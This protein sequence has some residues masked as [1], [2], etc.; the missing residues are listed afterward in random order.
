MRRKRQLLYTLGCLYACLA[1]LPL[2]AQLDAFQLYMDVDEAIFEQQICLDIK[3]EGAAQLEGLQFSLN[4]NPIELQYRG[5]FNIY[6]PLQ[7]A[8]WSIGDNDA[9]EGIVR[10]LMYDAAMQHDIPD[11]TV[12]AQ[13]CF[14]VRGKPGSSTPIYISDYTLEKRV[15]LNGQDGD[16]PLYRGDLK[17]VSDTTLNLYKSICASEV[18]DSSGIISVTPIGGRPPYQFSF[19]HFQNTN[20]NGLFGIGQEGKTSNISNLIPGRYYLRLRDQ[21]NTLF[22]DTVNVNNYSALRYNKI[23]T[24]PDC[25]SHNN[26]SI[27]INQIRGW[28]IPLFYS[29]GDGTLFFNQRDSLLAGEYQFRIQDV[30]NC[31]E[32]V[33][34]N[35]EAEGLQIEEIVQAPTCFGDA[36]GQLDIL[37]S[38]GTLSADSS[39][40]L[41]F[42]GDTMDIHNYTWENQAASNIAF[43]IFD[44]AA[45]CVIEREVQIPEGLEL[46]LDTILVNPI[47]CYGKQSGNALVQVSRIHGVDDLLLRYELIG[48]DTQLTASDNLIFNDLAAGTYPLIISDSNGNCAINSYFEMEQPTAI[49]LV[50]TSFLPVHC[51]D[52]NDGAIW[53]KAAGGTPDT[54]G[55]TY[56]WSNGIKNDSVQG[57]PS[58]WIE[59]TVK[60]AA[61]CTWD[62]SFYVHYE[63]GKQ[64]ENIV[65]TGFSCNQVAT[66][67]LNASL[68]DD[69]LDVVQ[70]IWS[71][72]KMGLSIDSLLPGNY[73][74]YIQDELQCWDTLSIDARPENAPKINQLIV[75][76]IRC[77]NEQNGS[78]EPVLE[79]NAAAYSYLWSNGDTTDRVTGLSSGAYWVIVR[80][81][82]NCADTAA[83]TL[84]NPDSLYYTID[85][86]HD[87]AQ[88]ALGEIIVRVRGGAKPYTI[89]WN[90]ATSPTDSILTDLMA[91]D[92]YLEIVD[93]FGCTRMDTIDVSDLVGTENLLQAE[94]VL[95]IF[96][97]PA[98]STLWLQSHH[99]GKFPIQVELYNFLG[100]KMKHLVLTDPDQRRMLDTS[101]YPDGTYVLL[102]TD[103][104]G[105]HLHAKVVVLK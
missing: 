92:I 25:A 15:I 23:L 18:G 28:S 14:T 83:S 42:E 86:M 45:S 53:V 64:I 66:G 1:A 80:D 39:Y 104:N 19:R 69:S 22:L 68:S 36:D 29:W 31:L 47:R 72:G 6:Q 21:D 44:S 43:T 82:N 10:I 67:M 46:E 100:K 7:N 52:G 48:V 89:Y 5:I 4:Y 59:L 93:A 40:H 77:H 76:N 74:L 54:T 61:R 95:S 30:H 55:Y 11:H 97:N 94:D 99:N 9:R 65:S 17:I 50:E 85:L 102:I 2:M 49:H 98:S 38:D 16:F 90:G 24:A 70:A 57:L 51:A 37:L 56:T 12:L 87:S 96:P 88:L 71:N 78:M 81:T 84:I 13:A 35:L 75:Q 32:I 91:G 41:I 63:E 3:T 20:F 27:L 26:G 103:A 73:D 33:D 79:T 105:Q 34:I 62:T 101:N 60:D 8:S 58:G